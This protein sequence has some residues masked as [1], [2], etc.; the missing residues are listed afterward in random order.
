MV[1]AGARAMVEER[2]KAR[3]WNVD[4]IPVLIERL[5]DYRRECEDKNEPLTSAGFVLA[6][7]VPQRTYYEMLNGDYD[8]VVEEYRLI[9]GIP[10]DTE[11]I[12]DGDGVITPLVP[13]SQVLEK[14]AR[15][16]LQQ[17][18][19]RNCYSTARGVNPAG[20]I[21]GLKAR[22]DWKEDNTAQHVTN[23]LVIADSTQAQKSLEMLFKP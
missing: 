13:F 18:L 5:E 9:H 10:Q 15:L 6:S 2:H 4:F 17:Q 16:P 20:S 11:T 22:F 1:E 23:N 14:Y 19:E 7:G 21:F 12:I 8:H 3:K